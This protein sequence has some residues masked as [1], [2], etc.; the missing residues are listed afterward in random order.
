MHTLKT[1][2]YIPVTVRTVAQC[3]Y[4][5]SN[6]R[7][8]LIDC[9][10]QSEEESDSEENGPDMHVFKQKSE[11][12]KTVGKTMLPSQNILRGMKGGS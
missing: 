12:G 5:G 9:S 11:M 6:G 3:I 4:N 10:S 1:S 2:F 7:S 8:V